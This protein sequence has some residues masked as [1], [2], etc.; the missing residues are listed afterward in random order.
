[1]VLCFAGLSSKVIFLNEGM[2]LLPVASSQLN[3][4]N[5]EKDTRFLAIFFQSEWKCFPPSSAKNN[6]VRRLLTQIL[7][8]SMQRKEHKDTW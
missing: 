1:M 5:Q 2:K 7:T 3:S 8:H 4:E 6:G